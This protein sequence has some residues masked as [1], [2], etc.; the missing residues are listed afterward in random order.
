[1]SKKTNVFLFTIV[2]TILNV[3]VTALLFIAL[4]W[5]YSVTLAPRLPQTAIVWAAMAG[6]IASIVVTIFIYRKVLDWARKKYNLDEQ[7]GLN[8][9]QKQ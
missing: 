2:A 5:L 4:M 8:K 3:V 6:F 1:M 9:K 7:L